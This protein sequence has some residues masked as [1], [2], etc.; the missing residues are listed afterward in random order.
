MQIPEAENRLIVIAY[1]VGVRKSNRTRPIVAKFHYFGQ[2][3]AVK[4]RLFDGTEQL[5][6]S[7]SGVGMSVA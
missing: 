3:E 1:R 5:K 6:P 2:K 4:S 7:N